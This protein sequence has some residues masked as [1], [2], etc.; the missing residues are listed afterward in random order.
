M[1]FLYNTSLTISSH[2]CFKQRNVQDRKAPRY[3]SARCHQRSLDHTY[4]PGMTNVP[5]NIRIDTQKIAYDAGHHV[6][7]VFF[8]Q[9]ATAGPS[10]ICPSQSQGPGHCANVRPGVT[11]IRWTFKLQRAQVTMR[12]IDQHGLPKP[13]TPNRNSACHSRLQF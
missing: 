10:L 11:S 4:A 1:V 6:L 9:R 2:I 5:R 7:S 12:V 8:V 3:R 13:T